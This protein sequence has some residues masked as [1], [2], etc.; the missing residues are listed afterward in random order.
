MG[1]YPTPTSCLYG[2][3][4]PAAL[5]KCRLDPRWESQALGTHATQLP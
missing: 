2:T 4:S 3:K 5:S 1:I